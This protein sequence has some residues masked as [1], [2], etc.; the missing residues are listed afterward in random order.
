MGYIMGIWVK[1]MNMD[2]C[3]YNIY[4][5]GLHIKVS[6]CESIDLLSVVIFHGY[7]LGM[8][9]AILM[10]FRWF[11][12]CQCTFPS[13]ISQRSPQLITRMVENNQCS[14]YTIIF[15]HDIPIKPSKYPHYTIIFP[16]KY[17]IDPQKI[18]PWYRYPH[19]TIISKTPAKLNTKLW[20][21]IFF[22]QKCSTMAHF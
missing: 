5:C 19:Y 6:D 3:V 9:M 22:D 1:W 4:I 13:G 7:I 12:P 16:S 20:C 11:S 15:P 2:M 17:I 14:H 21:Y 18:S 8:L 10:E